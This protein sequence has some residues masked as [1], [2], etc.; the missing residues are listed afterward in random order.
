MKYCTECGHVLPKPIPKH[1]PDCGDKIRAVAGSG[2]DEKAPG[3]NSVR[4]RDRLLSG[5]LCG[6]LV[7]ILGLIAFYPAIYWKQEEATGT[8]YYQ[9]FTM[10]NKDLNEL[11]SL[12]RQYTA[13]PLENATFTAKANAAGEY[14]LKAKQALVTWGYLNSFI[15]QNEGALQSWNVSTMDSQSKIKSAK[16]GVQDKARAMASELEGFAAADQGRMTSIA[17]TLETLRGLGN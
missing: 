8:Q 15:M 4:M 1:C 14:A 10:F 9:Y 5:V 3:W 13:M 17:G 2:G 12:D 7:L 6:F 16:S 11:N